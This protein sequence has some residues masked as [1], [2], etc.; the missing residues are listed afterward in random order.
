MLVRN[1]DDALDARGA[2]RL[3]ALADPGQMEDPVV[4]LRRACSEPQNSQS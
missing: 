2:Q 1:L 3:E 4:G